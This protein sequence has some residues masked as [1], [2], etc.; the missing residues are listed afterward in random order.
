[1]KISLTTMERRGRREMERPKVGPK[2]DERDRSSQIAQ[3]FTNGER[4]R[5]R[6]SSTILYQKLSAFGLTCSGVSM[7]AE[8]LGIGVRRPPLKHKKH[9][10]ALRE[11]TSNCIVW[12]SNPTFSIFG[13]TT[14]RAGD[15]EEFE[16]FVSRSL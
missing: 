15:L 16:V 2:G 10:F 13:Y 4:L 7:S 11:Q 6:I 14:G 5:R 1:M 12:K 3:I 8:L 9:R